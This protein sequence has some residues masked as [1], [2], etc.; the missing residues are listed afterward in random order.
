MDVG[1]LYF[2]G[3]L[4]HIVGT[5]MDDRGC[6][7]NAHSPRPCGLVLCIDDWVTFNLVSLNNE[8]LNEDAIE[9]CRHVQAL[10]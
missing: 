8:G 7:C 4:V 2:T 10:P 3:D 9:V 6:T 5:N 1:N